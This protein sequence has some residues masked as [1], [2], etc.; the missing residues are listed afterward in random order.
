MFFVTIRCDHCKSFMPK[1]NLLADHYSKIPHSEH[2]TIAK[3][4]KDQI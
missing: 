4:T 2:V 3:V 1:W